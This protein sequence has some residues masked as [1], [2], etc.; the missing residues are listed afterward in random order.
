MGFQKGLEWKRSQKGTSGVL[1]SIKLRS[2]PA[3]KHRP[4]GAEDDISSGE[5]HTTGKLRSEQCLPPGTGISDSEHR[6][7]LGFGFFGAAFL[8]PINY[9]NEGEALIRCR[10]RAR[11]RE[12]TKGRLMHKKCFPYG[13]TRGLQEVM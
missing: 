7:F 6:A 10:R 11:E 13:K 4:A 5:S 12:K 9:Y 8:Q 1:A 3:S 2:R